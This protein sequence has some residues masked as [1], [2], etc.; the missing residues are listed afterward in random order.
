MKRKVQTFDAEALM[1]EVR[2]MTQSLRRR[3]ADLFD[4]AHDMADFVP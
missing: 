2:S 4:V 1:H 3:N